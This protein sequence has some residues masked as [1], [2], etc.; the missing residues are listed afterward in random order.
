[1]PFGRIGKVEFPRFN[2]ED[3]LNWLYHCERFFEF[4]GISDEYKMRL[5]V[6][7]L[8]GRWPDEWQEYIQAMNAKF[9]EQ[10][11]E[12]PMDGLTNLV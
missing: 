2:C 1:M 9:N 12:D 7:Y 3:F 4:E 8:V 10:A 6:I 5:V 11:Y